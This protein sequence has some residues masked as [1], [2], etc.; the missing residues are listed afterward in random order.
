MKATTNN[1]IAAQAKLVC[2]MLRRNWA[3]A[4]FGLDFQ[5]MD[6]ACFVAAPGGFWGRKRIF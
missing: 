2:L 6:R 1:Q 3:G 4:D 5:A